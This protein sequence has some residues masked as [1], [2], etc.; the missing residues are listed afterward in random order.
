MRAWIVAKPIL[1]IGIAAYEAAALAVR[2]DTALPTITHLCHEHR[3][4][5]YSI[6]A[7]VVLHLVFPE[8]TPTIVRAVM[9]MARNPSS[10]TP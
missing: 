10:L 2:D 9:D 6:S 1:G 3:V 5:A 8:L 7:W 4:L